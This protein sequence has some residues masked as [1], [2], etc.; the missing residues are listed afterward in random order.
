MVMPFDPTA[1]V[2]LCLVVVS[3]PEMNEQELYDIAYYELRNKLQ[4]IQGV[5]AP[6]V[7]GGKLRRVTLAGGSVQTIAD[8]PNGRGGAWH[9]DGTILFTPDGGDALYAVPASGGE[10]V[11]VTQLK[12]DEFSHRFP[13]FVGV[14]LV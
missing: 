11:A 2:P 14:C 12:E 5:I 1:S 3:N 9:P 13:H 6:A 10:P 4:S 7:Y 8:A